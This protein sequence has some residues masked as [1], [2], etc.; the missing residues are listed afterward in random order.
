MDDAG[1]TWSG[2]GFFK[3]NSITF[4]CCT[5]FVGS[6]SLSS[7]STSACSPFRSPPCLPIPSSCFY[8]FLLVRCFFFFLLLSFW[9]CFSF[10]FYSEFANELRLKTKITCKV[11][12]GTQTEEGKRRRRGTGVRCL[13]KCI[14]FLIFFRRKI[15]M[16]FIYYVF[17]FWTNDDSTLSLSRS[18]IP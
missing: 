3:A 5:A 4:C 6:A 1:R 2:V 11:R 17:H 9:F 10:S 13:R 8:N 7:S 15:E 12:K 14:S 16:R 18:L